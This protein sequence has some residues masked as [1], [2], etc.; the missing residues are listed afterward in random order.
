MELVKDPQIVSNEFKQ[1]YYL[2]H[3]AVLRESSTSTKCRVVFNAFSKTSR[4]LSLNDCMMVGP[5]IQQDLFSIILRFRK[6]EIALTGDLVKMYRQIEV[7]PE[8]RDYLRLWWRENKSKNVDCFRL[9]TVTYG[10]G[11]APFL[12]TRTFQQLSID[13][14]E[15]FLSASLVLKKAFYMDDLLTGANSISLK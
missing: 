13:E 5:K 12:A 14:A 10:T 2:P 1:T 8:D 4:G 9:K 6:Y 11:C 7:R 15:Y 3:H